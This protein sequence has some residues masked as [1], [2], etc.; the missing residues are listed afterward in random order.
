VFDDDLLALVEIDKGPQ[1]VSQR[2]QQAV[3]VGRLWLKRQLAND[4]RPCFPV[5]LRIDPSHE[6]ISPQ[7]WQRKIAVLSFGCGRITLDPVPEPIKRFEPMAQN[8]QIV[9]RREDM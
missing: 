3:I 5:C 7:D 1:L 8:D 6:C 9:E 2:W 4:K